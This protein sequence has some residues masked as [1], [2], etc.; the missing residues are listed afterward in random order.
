LLAIFLLLS[1]VFQSLTGYRSKSSGTS[2]KALACFG[3]R[4]LFTGEQRKE[5]GKAGRSRWFPKQVL[6]FAQDDKS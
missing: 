1:S 2:W 4:R 5:S 6:R 3:E